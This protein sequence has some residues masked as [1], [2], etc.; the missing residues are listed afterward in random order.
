[1]PYNPDIHHRKSIR[2]KEYDYR[3]EGLYFITICTKN[4]RNL[5]GQVVSGEMNLN[6]IGDIVKE[7]IMKSNSLYENIR[8]ENYVVMP[9]HIHFII[10]IAEQGVTSNARTGNNYYSKIS[11]LSKTVS[12]CVRSLKARVSIKVKKAGIY[13]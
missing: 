2:L 1:M 3:R 4:R 6:E 7:E 10:E 12:V 9:N 11:P 5:F 13:L 8:I